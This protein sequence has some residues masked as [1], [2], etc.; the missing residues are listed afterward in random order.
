MKSHGLVVVFLPPELI[1]RF[2]L[3]LVG[4]DNTLCQLPGEISEQC[5]A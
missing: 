3:L 4:A 5:Q 2:P 1:S